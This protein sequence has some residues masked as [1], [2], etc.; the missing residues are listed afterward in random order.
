[1]K[2]NGEKFEF[3]I[4]LWVFKSFIMNLSGKEAVNVIIDKPLNDFVVMAG[5]GYEKVFKMLKVQVKSHFYIL[6]NFFTIIL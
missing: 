6:I 5:Q 2:E 1:M 3:S 4:C